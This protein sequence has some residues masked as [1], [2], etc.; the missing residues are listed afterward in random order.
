MKLH[1]NNP[2][3]WGLIRIEEVIQLGGNSLLRHYNE[4]LRQALL[5]IYPGAQ[6]QSLTCR[7]SMEKRMV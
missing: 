6:T 3:D 4:S 7:N 1:V 5:S 2:S